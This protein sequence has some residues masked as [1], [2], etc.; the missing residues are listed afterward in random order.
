MRRIVEEGN[1][2]KLGVYIFALCFGIGSAQAATLLGGLTELMG[3]NSSL[4]CRTENMGSECTATK[5][6]MGKALDEAQAA[7]LEIV[8]VV[9]M[10]SKNSKLPPQIVVQTKQHG[11]C[12]VLTTENGEE[13]EVDFLCSRRIGKDANSPQQERIFS[14]QNRD[15]KLTLNDVTSERQL[16]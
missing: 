4:P 16:K 11:R 3:Y 15:G 8:G 9:E 2:M 10:E 5:G 1:V 12:R 6:V 14:L 7:G 13:S